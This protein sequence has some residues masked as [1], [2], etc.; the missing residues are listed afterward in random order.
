VYVSLGLIKQKVKEGAREQYQ[1]MDACVRMLVA[2]VLKTL[3]DGAWSYL[4]NAEYAAVQITV[5]HRRH[6][7][8]LQVRSSPNV[9]IQGGSERTCCRRSSLLSADV[10][11]MTRNRNVPEDGCVSREG[12]GINVAVRS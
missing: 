2:R 12:L 8:R 3:G 1:A 7:R 9:S 10:F 11:L 6:N 4:E 5:S